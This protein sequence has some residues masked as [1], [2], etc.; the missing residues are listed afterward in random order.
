MLPQAFGQ[1][2]LQF[3]LSS[4]Q[5]STMFGPSLAQ[6]FSAAGEGSPTLMYAPG[7][8]SSLSMQTLAPVPGL[9]AYASNP[10]S[11]IPPLQ[12]GAPNTTSHEHGHLPGPSPAPDGRGNYLE[13][14][15]PNWHNEYGREPTQQDLRRDHV[16]H[17]PVR[18]NN[19]VGGEQQQDLG[20]GEMLIQYSTQDTGYKKSLDGQSSHDESEHEEDNWRRNSDRDRGNDEE[21]PGEE[22]G[23]AQDHLTGGS[24][25]GRADH[26]INPTFIGGNIAAHAQDY[27][28]GGPPIGRTGHAIN[29][30][31]IGDNIA[32]HAQD[33]LIGGPPIGRAGHAIN[34]TFIG[35][36]IAAHAQDHLTGGL[37]IGRAGHAINPTFI[38]GNIAAHAQDHLTG[39]SPIGRAGHAINPTFI[40]GNIAAHAQDHLTGGPPIGR[41]GYAVNPA[42]IGGNIAAHQQDRYYHPHMLPMFQQAEP[43]HPTQPPSDVSDDGEDNGDDN[44]DNGYNNNDR[45]LSRARRNSRNPPTASNAKPWQ[46]RFY[47]PTPVRRKMLERAKD[48]LAVH[49]LVVYAFPDPILS[50]VD[51]TQ[52]ITEAMVWIAHPK[53]G[54]QVIEDNYVDVH[55]VKLV[56]DNGSAFRSSIKKFM[57]EQVPLHYAL[58]PAYDALDPNTGKRYTSEGRQEHA[59][60][61][62]AA[63]IVD[64]K[65]LHSG[66][67]EYFDH[68]LIEL[69]IQHFIYQGRP[70]LAS[71]FPE[72]FEKKAPF[73]ALALMG[74]AVYSCLCDVHEGRSI[75]FSSLNYKAD[76]DAL[77][78]ALRQYSSSNKGDLLE[79]RLREWAV[80]KS[81]RNG[82][83]RLDDQTQRNLGAAEAGRMAQRIKKRQAAAGHPA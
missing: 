9:L 72:D 8:Q 18:S 37:P 44:D 40:G 30:T 23:R 79:D 16:N 49:L 43:S 10:T 32:A 56:L 82:P 29:P 15:A 35:G 46:L 21:T 24:P 6:S 25:I 81:S 66:T 68:P 11:N 12:T 2:G 61:K 57:H 74:V 60:E 62:A 39:G 41:A 19:Y 7:P 13:P 27:P 50:Q 69:G 53:Q 58:Y 70:S 22:E 20:G 1:G 34:P 14:Q 48:G 55:M 71:A 45:G 78:T 77:V 26:A 3:A 75:D 31:F 38:G 83:R 51:G 28:T 76:Y 36:N 42:F 63:L 5:G 65:F 52:I 54:N 33:H 4:G 73:R 47:D 64:S 17:T 59:A 80:G 67:D